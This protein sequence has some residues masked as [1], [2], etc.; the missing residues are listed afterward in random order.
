MFTGKNSKPETVTCEWGLTGKQ[1]LYVTLPEGSTYYANSQ[2]VCKLLTELDRGV[3]RSIASQDDICFRLE[4]V[5]VPH[6][7]LLELLPFNADVVPCT[8]S[9]FEFLLRVDL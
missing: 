1:A 4:N 7:V 6:E 9:P 2:D 5:A 8:R 3:L